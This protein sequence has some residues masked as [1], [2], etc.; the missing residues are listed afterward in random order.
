MAIFSENRPEW[1]IS[2]FAILLSR[3]VVVPI[4]NTLAPAQIAYQLKHSACRAAIVAGPK[5]WEILQ[6]L[7]AEL[8]EMEDSGVDGADAR[9][10]RVLCGNR[11]AR[12][13]LLMRR[14]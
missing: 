6:P 7:M 5:Q 2:D 8:P 14:R 1:H 13:R 4:Y 11:L 12:H 10:P 9:R 3:L